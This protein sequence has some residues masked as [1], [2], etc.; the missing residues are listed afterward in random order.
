[1][2]LYDPEPYKPGNTLRLYLL[3][4]YRRTGKTS[5]L[6][7]ILFILHVPT[8]SISNISTFTISMCVHYRRKPFPPQQVH[9]QQDL[10]FRAPKIPHIVSETSLHPAKGI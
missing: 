10:T 3:L 8:T 1:L 5:I 6:S 2:Q 9:K 4:A 7:Q